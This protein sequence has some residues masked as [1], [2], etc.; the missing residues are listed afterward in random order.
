VLE[1][2]IL[3]RELSVLPLLRQGVTVVLVRVGQSVV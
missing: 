1:L 3:L 2:A